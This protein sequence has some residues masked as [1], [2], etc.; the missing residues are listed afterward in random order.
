[1]RGGGVVGVATA[2]R[3]V[4]RL[5]DDGETLEVSRVCVLEGNKNAN[6]MLYGAIRRAATALGY[7]RLVTYTLPDE[8]GSSLRAVG[9]A[10]PI[11]IRIRS[12]QDGSKVRIRHDVNI[13]GERK[14]TQD[15]PKLRWDMELHR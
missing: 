9:F 1:M 11:D 6:S 8:S 4:A 10:D 7:R 13:W 3:P 14:M 12:W 15:V 2:G 5:L